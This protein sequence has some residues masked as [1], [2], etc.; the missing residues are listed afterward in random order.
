MD[1][2]LDLGVAVDGDGDRLIMVDS[3]GRELNGDHELYILAVRLNQKGVVATVMSNYGLERTLAEEGIEMHRTPVGD[4]YMLDELNRSGLNLAAEQSGH[5]IIN[6]LQP[7]GD[8]LMTAVQLLCEVKKS[9]KSLDRWRDEVEMLPQSVVNFSS[10][11]KTRI[12]QLEIQELIKTQASAIG[13]SGRLLVRAS[14]TEPVVR[15]MVEGPNA[16]AAAESIADEL[17]DALAKL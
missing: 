17:K 1:K 15:V 4:R 13:E 6:D 2:C 16:Q 8:A 14:G 9:G 11:N 3:R 5:V 7:T 10:E 12:D